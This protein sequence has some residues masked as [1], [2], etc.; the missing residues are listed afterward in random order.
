VREHCDFLARIPLYGKIDSL[1]AS[2]AGALALFEVARQ[3]R[4]AVPP[5]N[6]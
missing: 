1:N 2:V 5:P 4:A 6:E 3:R